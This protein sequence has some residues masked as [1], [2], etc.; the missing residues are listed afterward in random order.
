M[1]KLQVGSGVKALKAGDN[2]LR[3]LC[4][5]GTWRT[6]GHHKADDLYRIKGGLE[7]EAAATLQVR[8]DVS[9]C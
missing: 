9:F 1:R 6:F 7:L 5:P 4:P 3:G 2:V 8:L